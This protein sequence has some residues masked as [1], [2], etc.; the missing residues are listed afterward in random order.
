M[1]ADDLNGSLS[2]AILELMAAFTTLTETKLEKVHLDKVLPRFQKKGDAKTQ[3]WAKKILSNSELATKEAVADDQKKSA[4]PADGATGT[5]KADAV[6]KLGPEPVAGVKRAASSTADGGASKKVATVTAKSNGVTA[7]TRI[8]GNAGTKKLGETARP[9]TAAGAGATKK[10]VVAKPS[11]FFS[12][13]QSAAKKPG[14]SNAERTAKPVA[15][16]VPGSATAAATAKPAFSFAETM[17]NLAKPKKEEVKPVKQ[18]APAQPEETPE[19]RSKRMRKEQRRRLHVSFKTGEDL[20]EVRYFTHDPDE[21]ID[22]GSSQMRD[23]ADVGG[24]GRM[25]KQKHQ[26]MDLDDD[27]DSADEETKL[28]EFHVPS[29]VDF[30]M[31]PDLDKNWAPRGGGSIQP[32]SNERAKRDQYESSTLMVYYTNPSEIPPNPKEPEN[33]YNGDQGGPVKMFGSLDDKWVARARDVAARRHSTQFQP[34]HAHGPVSQPAPG[35]DFSAQ[36]PQVTPD[37]QSILES[38]KQIAA[39]QQPTMPTYAPPYMGTNGFQPPPPPL[40]Q[41]AAVPA[42]NID[43]AAIL[44]QIQ[45]PQQQTFGQQGQAAQPPNYRTKVCR[46][47]QAG[48][49]DKGDACSYLHQ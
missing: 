33:P 32:N 18:E 48:K 8:T 1:K 21:E 13:L 30:S 49:C 43:L 2:R 44:A 3:F 11:G 26:M 23:M 12:S 40:P 19:E 15:A 38:L 16:K 45:Q 34:H 27:E 41:P 46:F 10:T 35:Y 39:Q 22:H 36:Q 24:E 20:V 7:T 47:F 9:A 6:R 17:A 28:V 42:A 37:V 25:L 29:Q 5:T 4:R 31:N 14:T